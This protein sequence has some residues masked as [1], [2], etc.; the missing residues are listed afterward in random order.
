MGVYLCIGQPIHAV[1]HLNA[2]PLS[3]FLDCSKDGT[4]KRQENGLWLRIHEY[5]A[6]NGNRVF[7]CLGQGQHK[8]KKKAE[9]IGCKMALDLIETSHDLL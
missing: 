9:Q 4:N 7:I 1:N 3:H 6:K 8:I 5:M 2:L